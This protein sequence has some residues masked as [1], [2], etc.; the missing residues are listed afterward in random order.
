MSRSLSYFLILIGGLVAIYAR[1]EAQQ[2]QFLLIGGIVVLMFGVYSISRNI[3]S[4][5]DTD[6]NDN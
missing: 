4:K 3:S 5:N 2:N 6:D 1:A